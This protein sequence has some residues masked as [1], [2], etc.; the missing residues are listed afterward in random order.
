MNEEVAKI[1]KILKERKITYAELSKMSGVAHGTLNDI[2]RGKTPT[3]RLDTMQAIKKALG[4][5]D[6]GWTPEE[7]AQ[8]VS[9]TKKV[10]VTPDE[11]EL[12]YLYSR[13]RSELGEIGASTFKAIGEL[14]LNMHNR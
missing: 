4:L 3:P 6:I 9:A 5:S 7:K 13:I 12:L 14:L 8:G 11:D 2:F 10:D 1:K